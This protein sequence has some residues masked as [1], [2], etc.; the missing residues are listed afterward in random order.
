MA[1]KK[2]V[3]DNS[4]LVAGW[5]SSRQSYIRQILDL[6]REGE[7]DVYISEAILSELKAALSKKKN[8]K[9]LNEKH[10]KIEELIPVYREMCI[11]I[12][13]IGEVNL[14]RDKDDNKFLGLAQAVEADFL[15]TVDEDLLVLKEFEGTV[16]LRPKE[17]WE[18][19]ES[20]WDKGL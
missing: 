20:E 3:I 8:L 16:I 18:R 9:I 10:Q 4:A 5:L 15:V 2:L 6:V 19:M 7:I 11:Q 17:T 1:V 12:D 13:D 14:S